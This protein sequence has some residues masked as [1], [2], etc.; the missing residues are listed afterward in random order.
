MA[1]SAGPDIVESSLLLFLDA[2]N[3]KSYP[4]TGTAWIDIS[5]AGNVGSFVNGVTFD[6]S[7]TCAP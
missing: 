7:G 4:G 3:R 1:V 5:G 2:G 6:K